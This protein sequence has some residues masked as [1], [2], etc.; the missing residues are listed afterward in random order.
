[1]QPTRFK[2]HAE[3]RTCNPVQRPNFRGRVTKKEP[4]KTI[5]PR[6]LESPAREDRIER[7]IKVAVLPPMGEGHQPVGVVIGAPL[8]EPAQTRARMHH[9]HKQVRIVMLASLQ[10]PAQTQVR[11]YHKHKHAHNINPRFGGSL[12]G[13]SCSRR[14]VLEVASFVPGH[15]WN[16]GAT[17]W[18]WTA[19]CSKKNKMATPSGTDPMERQLSVIQT[20]AND[21]AEQTRCPRRVRWSPCRKEATG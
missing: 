3:E 19:L 6:G 12:Q 2:L 8:Q 21:A 17:P 13:C 1:M 11:M 20:G 7:N 15:V 9:K 14:Q 18:S 4:Q 5:S 10:E 16:R